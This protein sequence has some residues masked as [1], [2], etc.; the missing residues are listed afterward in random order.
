MITAREQLALARFVA[1]FLHHHRWRVESPHHYQCPRRVLSSSSAVAT[2][3]DPPYPHGRSANTHLGWMRCPKWLA[4]MPS[5]SL[6]PF[7]AAAL[8]FGSSSERCRFWLCR[9][10][11]DRVPAMRHRDLQ[12]LWWMPID[13]RSQVHVHLG[14]AVGL[15]TSAGRSTSCSSVPC[16]SPFI[17]WMDLVPPDQPII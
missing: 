14:D 9:G 12:L 6:F 7:F 1:A 4:W 2:A 13:H 17:W 15:S 5:A 8:C 3:T 10:S 11:H 16:C